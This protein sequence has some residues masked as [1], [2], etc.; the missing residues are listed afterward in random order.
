MSEV[1]MRCLPTGKLRSGVV[2]F[3][4][5]RCQH[6]QLVRPGAA[7]CQRVCDV[8]PACAHG[9]NPNCLHAV[10]LPRLHSHGVGLWHCVCNPWPCYGVRLWP[11]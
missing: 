7:L 6:K 9:S 4:V 5:V 2:L 10:A 3:G 1:F 8:K 11:T